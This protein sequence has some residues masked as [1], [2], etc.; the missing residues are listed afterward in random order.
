MAGV[1]VHGTARALP[2]GIFEREE[3][4]LLRRAPESRFDVP[5]WANAKV[6]PDHHVQVLKALYSVPTKYIGRKVRVRADRGMV[7]SPA[8][9]AR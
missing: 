6:H 5:H 3:Q 7:R 1:R 2:R 9:G 4:P 8:G